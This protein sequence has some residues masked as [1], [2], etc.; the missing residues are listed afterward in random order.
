[1]VYQVPSTWLG[2]D[3]FSSDFNEL[4]KPI[5]KER[6]NHNTWQPLPDQD[7]AIRKKIYRAQDWSY[8]YVDQ[9][10]CALDCGYIISQH[11]YLDYWD[12]Y[13]DGWT[14]EAFDEWQEGEEL[15]IERF[16]PYNYGCIEAA[17][18]DDA[19]T[20]T[21]SLQEGDYKHFY[22]DLIHPTFNPSSRDF[23]EY[24][25]TKANSNNSFAHDGTNRIKTREE[26]FL[27]NEDIEVD[28]PYKG[29]KD[30]MHCKLPKIALGSYKDRKGKT[31]YKI[32]YNWSW[33]SELDS[34]KYDRSPK[35]VG[36][37]RRY[38]M[39]EPERLSCENIF[40]TWYGRELCDHK[41]IS[42]LFI[43]DVDEDPNFFGR[44]YYHCFTK[45]N[46]ERNKKVYRPWTLLGPYFH[47]K[48]KIEK[49]EDR[50]NF[51]WDC[52]HHGMDCQAVYDINKVKTLFE[53]NLIDKE[54]LNLGLYFKSVNDK[55]CSQKYDISFYDEFD[56]IDTFQKALIHAPNITSRHNWRNNN[57]SWL[58]WFNSN[59]EGNYDRIMPEFVNWRNRIANIYSELQYK[60]TNNCDEIDIA[61]GPGNWCYDNAH[62]DL[63]S[64][65]QIVKEQYLMEPPKF[66]PKS[67]AISK[68]KLDEETRNRRLKKVYII[69]FSSLGGAAALLIAFR[70]LGPYKWICELLENR[71]HKKF[72]KKNE[73]LLTNTQRTFGP[74][75]A[76]TLIQTMSKNSL[77]ESKDFEEHWERTLIDSTSD[78]TYVT[79]E[80]TKHVDNSRELRADDYLPVF[81]D[82][83][84]T[85]VNISDSTKITPNQSFTKNISNSM[86]SSTNY[87]NNDVVRSSRPCTASSTGTSL[88]ANWVNN[89]FW[90]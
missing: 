66:V 33:R 70:F 68:A 69:T 71:Q 19:T 25:F 12:C 55:K 47:G 51:D 83:C 23:W 72:I 11:P 52:K 7:F 9:F 73:K 39:V 78:L 1:M 65:S 18:V 49:L 48:A 26:T 46:I 44:N 59:I 28:V 24:D 41:G 74:S 86:K 77:T 29:I 50:I 2:W 10:H 14:K 13:N 90:E 89:G 67:L 38:P 5:R 42:E 88:P 82:E 32:P 31:H 84:L 22:F 58:I 45:T 81:T 79:S 61:K 36:N 85:G 63:H 15:S 57:G 8:T 60:L 80:I 54:D 27:Q 87:T 40:V 30:L 6:N 64:L 16:T 3:L 76:N 34:E 4:W 43:S 37:C 75:L 17:H 62:H 20:P 35:V 56:V 53:R 21:Y